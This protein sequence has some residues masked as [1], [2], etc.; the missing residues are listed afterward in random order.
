MEEEALGMENERIDKTRITSS[1]FSKGLPPEGGR[2]NGASCWSASE[3]NKYQGIQV[4]LCKERV[5]T[6]IATQ[7]RKSAEE[8]VVSY[9]V[10]YSLDRENFDDYKINGKI[11]VM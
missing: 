6:A 5:V 8:W 11:E 3:N 2:L 4:D 9:A 1:S 10:S 7:G